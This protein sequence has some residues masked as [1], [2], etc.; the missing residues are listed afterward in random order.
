EVRL[1]HPGGTV[2]YMHTVGHPVLNSSGELVQFVGSSMDIT[3]RKQSEAALR[4]SEGYL[5][6]AQR[7]SQTGSWAWRSAGYTALHLSEEW[8]RIYDF[9]PEVGMPAWEQLLG[10]IHPDDRAKWQRTLDR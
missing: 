10:R 8:Y 4:R 7:L 1:L 2:K 9:N 3:E 5:A 6:E